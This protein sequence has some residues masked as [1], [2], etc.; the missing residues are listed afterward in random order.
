MR[1]R[2]KR[3]YQESM[4]KKSTSLAIANSRFLDVSRFHPCASRPGLITEIDSLIAI[5]VQ[6]E[7]AQKGAGNEGRSEKQGAS[8]PCRGRIARANLMRNL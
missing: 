6:F 1:Q 7:S 2:L 8:L 3:V 4:E 5:P